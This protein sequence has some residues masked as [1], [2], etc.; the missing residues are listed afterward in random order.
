[1]WCFCACNAHR[2]W[3]SRYMDNANNATGGLAMDNVTATT[4]SYNYI[5]D[6]G[7][8]RAYAMASVDGAGAV[9]LDA[10]SAR[11]QMYRANGAWRYAGER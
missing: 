10:I 9:V 1:M 3:Y 8:R 11:L 4:T 5:A 2:V 7:L 6:Y